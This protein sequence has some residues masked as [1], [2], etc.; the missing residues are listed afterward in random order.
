MLCCVVCL[1]LCLC[2]Y[3]GDGGGG[4]L[5][6]FLGY[7]NNSMYTH[8]TYWLFGRSY[9]YPTCVL[10]FGGE[11]LTCGSTGSLSFHLNSMVS[12]NCFVLLFCFA[13]LFWFCSFVSCLGCPFYVSSLINLLLFISL[14]K[15]VSLAS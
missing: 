8:M 13:V 11:I 15:I 6:V 14:K 1:C 2:V 3:V 12:L 9:V 10:L 4:F 7:H 5:S